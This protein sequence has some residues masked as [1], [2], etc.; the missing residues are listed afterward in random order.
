MLHL[1]IWLGPGITSNHTKWPLGTSNRWEW[2]CGGGG[3]DR[4]LDQGEE[5]LWAEGVRA[6]SLDFPLPPPRPPPHSRHKR[7]RRCRRFLERNMVTILL[8]VCAYKC[9]L[10]LLW[11]LRVVGC[12]M[13]FSCCCSKSPLFLNC[14][15]SWCTC[16]CFTLFLYLFVFFLLL[17]LFA[18]CC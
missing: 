17:P 8:L 7:Y 13:S 6:V 16:R 1:N 10:V 5:R 15:A 12:C 14:A 3:G 11:L 4:G 18:A 2:G 9:F